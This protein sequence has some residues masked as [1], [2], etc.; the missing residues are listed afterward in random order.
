MDE[1][2]AAPARDARCGERPG[3]ARLIS[4]SGTHELALLNPAIKLNC[5][6]LVT[7]VT[8]CQ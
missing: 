6:K 3:R 7:L 8:G 2:G 4:V 1:A 5:G